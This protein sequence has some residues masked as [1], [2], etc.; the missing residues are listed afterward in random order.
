[1][2]YLLSSFKYGY[3]LFEI[4]LEQRVSE[5]IN[6]WKRIGWVQ[7]GMKIEQGY[8]LGIKISPTFRRCRERRRRIDGGASTASPLMKV[9][10]RRIDRQDHISFHTVCLRNLVQFYATSCYLI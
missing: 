2:P 5:G 10:R 1:M 6:T 3:D 4:R 9:R 8:I 7:I